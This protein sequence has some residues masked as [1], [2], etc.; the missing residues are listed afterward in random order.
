[1][2]E[3]L[4]DIG[5]SLEAAVAD[6]IDNSITA[7]AS[8]I[9]IRFGWMNDDPW[10]AI[11]DDGMGMIQSEL[12]EAMRPGSRSPLDT[13]TKDDLGRFGL[14]M[15]TASFS[16]CRCLTVVTRKAGVM[17]AMRWDLDEVSKRDEWILLSVSG[18]EVA[19]L[20]AIDLLGLDGT[21]V[22]WQKLDRLDLGALGVKAHGI[23]N[24]RMELVRHHL[25]IVFHRFLL[26]EPGRK[27]IKISINNN[28][29]ESFD[30]F[31]ERSFATNPLQ[32][33]RVRIDG[34][35]VVMQPFILPHH[36]KVTPEEY[37][38]LAGSDGYLRSQGFY[39]YRNRR[40]I[41][42]G[43]WFRL[44]RL[45]ELTKLA[46]VR[47]DIPNTLDHLWNIDVRK[48]RAHPPETVRQRM[49]QIVDK[50]REGAK[51]PYTHRSTLVIQRDTSAVWCRR[52]FNDRVQ[53]EI[54]PKHPLI[55]ELLMDF[56]ESTRKQILAVLKM[57]GNSF[58]AAVF[59]SDY[60][61]NPKALE[62]S[63]PDLELL[64]DLARMIAGSNP[65]ISADDLKTKLSGI[66]PFSFWEASLGKVISE[67]KI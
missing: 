51:R 21:F 7:L 57:I 8:C 22:L 40:L 66:D 14:G 20:P 2:I 39:I 49:R 26:G 30:P 56:D 9:S 25:A 38:R 53:F 45:E 6:I 60:A 4:R 1:M 62:P 48:S 10:I 44:A 55:N 5:Y 67:I 35:Y 17:S 47:V 12:V 33:E 3:A 24:E 11:C 23:L 27:K 28:E 50:I 13:R 29:I 65:G 42:Y 64:K 52:V 59:F 43:T 37:E 34:D 41:L 54:D 36:T 46:R 16:Q 31:N 18:N 32:E 15:K 61:S 63:E 19:A 58:P